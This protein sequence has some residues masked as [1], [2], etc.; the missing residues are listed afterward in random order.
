MTVHTSMPNVPGSPQ[1][2]KRTDREPSEGYHSM[3]ASFEV[4]T[5]R[6]KFPGI[7]TSRKVHHHAALQYLWDLSCLL[8]KSC[9]VRT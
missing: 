2:L 3:H 1:K 7:R 5:S 8:P 4:L 6:V 9:K